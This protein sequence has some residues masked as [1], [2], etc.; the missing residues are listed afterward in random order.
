ML[1]WDA[2]Q[3]LAERFRAHAGDDRHLYAWAIRGMADDWE[4]G[5]PV[6]EVCAGYENAPNGAALQLRLLA[7]VF[8]L[9]L[10]GQ[11]PELVPF[12]ACLGGTEPPELAWPVM[13]TTIAEHLASVREGLEIAPQTNEVGRSVA[14]LAGLFDLAAASGVRRI[15]LLELGASAGLNLLVDRFRFSGDDWTWGPPDATVAL[16]DSVEGPI[17][18][19]PLEIVARR[20]CD[21]SPVDPTTDEGSL[22]LTSFVWPFDLHR[23]ARL[24]GAL[25]VAREHPVVVD[26]AAARSWLPGQLAAG[27]PTDL[28]VVWHSITQLYWPVE[29]VQAVEQLLTDHGGERLLGQVGMEFAPGGASNAMPELRTQL[30]RPGQPVRRRRLGTVHH[31]GVP[32]RLTGTDPSSE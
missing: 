10:R 1:A 2:G 4:A 28:T 3:T 26:R 9:V 6:R 32:V 11:A 20:G 24:A 13:R 15:R 17:T 29:E 5:G 23:H 21:L 30:W 25:T 19:G 22:L 8:R 27:D 14:L 7:A 16:L 31:H 12:Y 18:P